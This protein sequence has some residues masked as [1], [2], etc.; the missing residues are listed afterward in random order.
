MSGKGKVYLVGAGPGSADLITVRGADILKTAD[1]IIYDK[2]ANPA[3]L[4]FARPNAELIC[5]PKRIGPGSATQDQINNLLVEKAKLGQTIVRLKGGDP[6][7]FGRIGQE[8]SALT[9]AGI[10]FEIVPGVTA[11]IAAAESA[12]IILTDR[13]YSSQ[14]VFITGQE[15]EGKQKSSIDW[16][17]LAKFKGT[18]VFYMA[19]ENLEFIAGQLIKNGISEE[20]PAAVIA[21]ATLPNQKTVRASLK[22]ISEK[23]KE[24]KIEPPAIVVIG[25]AADEKLNWLMNKPLFGKSIVVTRDAESNA[26]FAAKIIAKG[27]CPIEFPTIKIEPLTQTNIFLQTLAKLAEYDWIIFTSANGVAAFFDA[28]QNLGK[29]ARVFASA[30][31]AA[32]GSETA[33]K[34]SEFAIVA[35]FTPNVFTSKELGKQLIAFANLQNKKVLLLRSQLASN[36]LSKLLESAGAEVDNVPVYTAVTIKN[37]CSWLIEKIERGEI[38]WLTFASPS[39][40]KAFFEQIPAKLVDSSNVRVA[41]IG[42]VTSEQLKNLGLKVDA[43]ATEHTIDG[44]LTAIEK[45]YK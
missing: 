45:T 37:K 7:I 21:D 20:T 17:L 24:N 38:D 28:L 16:K 31:I 8:L 1:C 25:A 29:D 18:I 33:A 5:V 14:V 32:I 39:S 36:E 15:A 13:D 12:G 23:C 6:C 22:R 11:A 2:L 9:K 3:L 43:Q 41:S 27:G 30:K 26:D 35:D 34:L 42:P 4:K 19:L 44:L 10:D 40:A